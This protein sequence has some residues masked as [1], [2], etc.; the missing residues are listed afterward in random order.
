MSIIG[1]DGCER[2]NGTRTDPHSVAG[3]GTH[4]GVCAA[5]P[6]DERDNDGA[7]PAGSAP[8][9]TPATSA[10]PSMPN[11]PTTRIA[12]PLDANTGRLN[13]C[14]ARHVEERRDRTRP[15][16]R[17]STTRHGDRQ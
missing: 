11:R 1:P 10:T 8:T 4:P 17:R 15:R 13:D 2:N 14:G 6:T 3:T 7:P 12:D 16:Q 5:P 9:A